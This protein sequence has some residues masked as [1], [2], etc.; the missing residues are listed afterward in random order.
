MNCI[1]KYLPPSN[2]CRPSIECEDVKTGDIVERKCD[3]AEPFAAIVFKTISDPYV[4]RLN[5]LKL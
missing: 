5:L 2:K 4:G 3:P 1:V